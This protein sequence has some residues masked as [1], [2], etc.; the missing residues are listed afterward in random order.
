MVKSRFSY[1]IQSGR[2]VEVN[3]EK[4]KGEN[5]KGMRA[6]SP[7]RN[8]P[9]SMNIE[10]DSDEINDKRNL[11]SSKEQSAKVKFRIA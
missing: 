5:V 10:D 8:G 4:F 3:V 11:K 2:V 1:K 6:I 9:K 7:K